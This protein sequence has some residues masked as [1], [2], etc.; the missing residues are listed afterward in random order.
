MKILMKI[1]KKLIIKNPDYYRYFYI[2]N[3][4]FESIV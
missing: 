1:Y 2:K 4:L 3:G